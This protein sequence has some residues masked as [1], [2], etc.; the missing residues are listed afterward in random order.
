MVGQTAVDKG[1][2]NTLLGEEGP[3]MSLS[4]DKKVL[5]VAG[6]RHDVKAFRNI[7]GVIPVTESAPAAPAAG[8]NNKTRPT[9]KAGENPKGGNNPMNEQE[10]RAQYPELVAS[11]ERAAVEAA[12]T[13]IVASERARLQAIEGIVAQIGDAQLSADAT[14]GENACDAAQLTLQAMQKQ[15]AQG[16]AHLAAVKND[17][18]NSGVAEVNSNPNGGNSDNADDDKAELDGIV[19]AYRSMSGGMKK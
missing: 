11:I 1:F 14:Y 19:N 10:L 17:A 18:N 13:E 15:A 6:V 4:A 8:T 7:P 12:R 16:A 3:T 5:L 9:N 2:A